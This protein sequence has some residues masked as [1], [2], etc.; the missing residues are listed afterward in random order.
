MELNRAAEIFAWIASA[1]VAGETIHAQQPPVATANKPAVMVTH[2][3]SFEGDWSGVLQVGE[4]GLQLVLQLSKDPR[5]EWHA[6]LDSLN[7]AIYGIEAS[8]VTREQ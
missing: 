6:K 3:A 1:A 8:K 2:T 5:G 4:T 7:Q